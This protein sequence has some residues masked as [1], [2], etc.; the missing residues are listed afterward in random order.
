[1][2]GLAAI[3]AY[4]IAHGVSTV[5]A[6]IVFLVRNEHRI[7]KLETSLNNLKESHDALTDHGTIRHDFSETKL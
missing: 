3:Q 1:M 4:L 5:G 6:I 2:D 7:T